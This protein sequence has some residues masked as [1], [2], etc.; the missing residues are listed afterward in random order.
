MK[1]GA[2]LYDILGITQNA[3][4]AELQAAYRREVNALEA[5]RG[6]IGA[7]EFGDR[8]QLLRLAYSTL[9][10]AASRTGYD[11]KLASRTRT[12]A[13]AAAGR[14][15]ATLQPGPM[16]ASAETRADA[17]SLRADAL[18]LRADAMLVRAGLDLPLETHGG[19]AQAVASG[20]FTFLKRFVRAI[21]LLVLIGIVTYA[22]ARCS[23]GDASARRVA[24]EAKAN[25]QTAL[26][27]YFQTHGVRPANMAELELL[28]ADRRRRENE[29]RQLTQDRQ[30]QEQDTRRFEEEARRRAQQVSAELRRAEDLARWEAE[31]ERERQFREE[32]IKQ[33]A[34]RM[35]QERE[36]QQWREELRR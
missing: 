19:A 30:K 2:T 11:S 6:D 25:E 8:M 35:Q 32:Q 26:Q 18:A 29:S 3:G 24:M 1:T 31:R 17:L 12:P 15:L 13:A 27:E 16:A 4:G 34:K 21:G 22:I 33:H 9:S 28:E 10:D 36:R 20:T 14:A 5:R 7:Q 23:F